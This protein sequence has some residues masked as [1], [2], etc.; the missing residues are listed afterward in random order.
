MKRNNS[1]RQEPPNLAMVQ[2]FS[3]FDKVSFNRFFRSPKRL[4]TGDYS[5]VNVH[6]NCMIS[7]PLISKQ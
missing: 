6:T 4:Q 2:S 3:T 7:C 5:V 1:V